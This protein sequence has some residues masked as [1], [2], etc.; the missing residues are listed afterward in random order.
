MHL[1]AAVL[2][3]R[4]EKLC[5][6][7]AEDAHGNILLWNGEV[8]GVASFVADSSCL[9]YIHIRRPISI[10]SLGDCD[11]DC[12]LSGTAVVCDPLHSV[13][14]CAQRQEERT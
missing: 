2:H 9:D 7:P 6:Q 11:S 8:C 1:I 5:A 12:R 14:S 10:N 3:L 13:A 4:G